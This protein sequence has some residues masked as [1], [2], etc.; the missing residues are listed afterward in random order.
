MSDLPEYRHFSELEVVPVPSRTH[1]D[2]EAVSNNPISTPVESWLQH[3]GPDPI[4]VKDETFYKPSQRSIWKRRR[5]WIAVVVLV[6][7]VVSGTLGGVLGGKGGESSR[8]VIN[9]G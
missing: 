6:L 1:E 4:D 9:V 2:L 8:L 3:D 5:F 7:I